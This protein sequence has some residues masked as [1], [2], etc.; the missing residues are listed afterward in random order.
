MV[1]VGLEMYYYSSFLLLAA[2]AS[3]LRPAM[4][5]NLLASLLLVAMPGAIFSVFVKT[6]NGLHLVASIATNSFLLVY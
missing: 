2:M 4:A 3:N 5:S 1:G 6:G